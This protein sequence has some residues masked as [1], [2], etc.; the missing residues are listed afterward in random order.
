MPPRHRNRTV[1]VLRQCC[2]VTEKVALAHCS[3]AMLAEAVA[4][5]SDT[6]CRACMLARIPK[7]SREQTLKDRD[8]W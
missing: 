1:T 3:D 6:P 8:R 7:Q 5:E 4:R 2:G